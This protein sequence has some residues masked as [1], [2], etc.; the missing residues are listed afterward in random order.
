[1][2]SQVVSDALYVLEPRM[3][4]AD[5]PYDRI[6]ALKIGDECAEQ[7]ARRVLKGQFEELSR[8]HGIFLNQRNEFIQQI[9]WLIQKYN[10]PIVASGNGIA[11]DSGR[12]TERVTILE[13]LKKLLE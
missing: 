10:K 7:T 13:D 5:E 9:G 11:F 1:M 2:N 6:S 4:M 8:E 12:Q 3:K